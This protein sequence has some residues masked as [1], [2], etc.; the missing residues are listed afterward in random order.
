MKYRVVNWLVKHILNLEYEKG[1][2]QWTNWNEST[3]TEE[4]MLVKK[5]CM[6][7]RQEDV[8]L[9]IVGSP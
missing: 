5:L 6:K 8:G 4:L 9:D 3:F 2:R 1:S 7:I